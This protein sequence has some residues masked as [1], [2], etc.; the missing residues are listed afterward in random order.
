MG[1]GDSDS[2]AG[3]TNMHG[4]D[5]GNDRHAR[6]QNSMV[7]APTSTQTALAHTHTL[8]GREY[9]YICTTYTVA[10]RHGTSHTL[11]FTAPTKTFHR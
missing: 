10:S 6:E 2:N 8:N 3:T 7:Q 5:A 11:D 1:D 9:R 4:S